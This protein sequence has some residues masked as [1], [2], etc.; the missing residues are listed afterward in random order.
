MEAETTL[1]QL[2]KVRPQLA[3]RPPKVVG[4]QAEARDFDHDR[5]DSS[6]D[7][8]VEKWRLLALPEVGERGKTEARA[9]GLD[10]RPLIVGQNRARA[11]TAHVRMRLKHLTEQSMQVLDLVACGGPRRVPQASLDRLTLDLAPIKRQI[12]RLRDVLH[13]CMAD[14]LI[15]PRI[16]LLANMRRRVEVGEGN[17]LMTIRR[18]L[19]HGIA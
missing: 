17:N 8:L 15:H 2:R 14:G 7:H 18:A 11:H 1:L 13:M 10:A 4:R 3:E 9:H 16:Q 19:H 6:A 12:H 5:V